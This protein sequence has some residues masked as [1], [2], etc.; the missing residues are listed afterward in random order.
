MGPRDDLG[1]RPALRPPPAR[2]GRLRLG[3]RGGGARRGG[4]G[5][6]AARGGHVDPVPHQ[7]CPSLAGDVRAQ[8]V[9][10][11][12]PGLAA[13]GRH[14]RRGAAVLARRAPRPRRG[15]RHRL[16]GAGRPRGRRRPA[17]R[18]RHAL[19]AARRRRGGGRSRRPL[20]R[21][22]QGRHAGRAARRTA[23]RGHAR[24][25]LPHARRAVAGQRRGAGGDRDG[26]R[27]TGGDHGGQAR[28]GDVRGGARPA[29]PGPHPRGRRPPR[30]RRGGSAAR[31]GGR[32]ARA[33]R[34][35]PARRS[36]GRRAAAH[37]RG[38]LA[39]RPGARLMD[40]A[41]CLIGNPH[42]GA[43]RAL[44]LLPGVEAALRAQGRTFRVERT[45][46]REHA[47]S[48]ARGAR[49]GG[50]LVAAMGGDGLTG[51]VAGELRDGAGVLAILPG[52]RGNDFARKL[53]IPHDPV[54]ACELLETGSERRVDLA[55][56]GGS[57]YLGIVSAG[58]DSDVNRIANET[59]LKLGTLVYVYGCL[60]AIVA[61]REARWE[62]EIDGERRSFAGYSVAVA[63]SGVFG[64]GMFLAPDASLEDGSLD[65]VTIAHQSKLRYL[66]GLP[67]VFNGSHLKDPAI[68]IVQGREITFA[69]D[70]PFTAYADGDPIG[71]LPLTVRVLPG[72]LRVVAPR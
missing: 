62:L 8:A 3:G 10:A 38:R 14:R 21:R 35:H 63:N 20:L 22:A 47:R 23:D 52:G 25:H 9:E 55:E 51:A 49:D 53:R 44:R 11:R 32:R 58:I 60:R 2:P 43:G 13:G 5:R 4:G 45:T 28:A 59:R 34:G 64:G 54:A 71:E 70:R 41:V 40:G 39:R 19:R 61:W 65:V 24:R 31:G 48:L 6:R 27:A 42:A 18:Q 7:Q 67:R 17:D 68:K 30:R 69:A 66:R 57:V 72:A 12:L 46:S 26:D 33:D 36:R 37:V 50:E 56:A 29:R 1:G 15:V 16:P